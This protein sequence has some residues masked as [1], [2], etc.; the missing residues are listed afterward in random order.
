MKGLRG[1]PYSFKKLIQFLQGNIVV[2]PPPSII[3]AVP[4]GETVLVP[5]T[6]M[7][8]FGKKMMFLTL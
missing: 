2:D 3:D 8:L 7:E 4:T 1:K 5:L 6:W